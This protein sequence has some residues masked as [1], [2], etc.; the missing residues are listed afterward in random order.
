V[1]ANITHDVQ[2]A[3][4]ELSE[5]PVDYTGAKALWDDG[6]HSPKGDGLR[7][8]KGMATHDDMKTIP[9]AAHFVDMYGEDWLDNYEQAALGG[10]GDFD[11]A[12]DAVRAMAAKKNMICT[13]TMYAYREMED[14]LTKST[15]ADMAHAWDEGVA[16][17]YGPEDTLTTSYE[18]GLPTSR[19]VSEK[20]DADF[21]TNVATEIEAA[22]KEGLTASLAGETA[23]MQAALDDVVKGM[24][25]TFI[26]ATLKYSYRMQVKLEVDP[27]DWSE[28]YTYWRCMAGAVYGADADVAREVEG[29]LTVTNSNIDAQVYC[30]TKEALETVYSKLGLTA[31]DV[32][33]FNGI[34]SNPCAAEA[35]DYEEE[36]ANVDEDAAGVIGSLVLAAAA[37]AA[38]L[39]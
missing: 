24:A 36:M 5:D 32:G 4:E 34:T 1:H 7:T 22:W 39:L 8:L 15:K 37:A 30:K 9:L 28:G 35:E 23:S 29:Y 6:M 12:S 20:R 31:G 11:G 13:T 2:D 33:T 26:Q 19:Q 18:T 3:M 21:D 10:T 27:E 17:W 25:T 14:A 16:F 38:A